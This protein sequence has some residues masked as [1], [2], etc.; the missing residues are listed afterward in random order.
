MSEG[1]VDKKEP[2]RFGPQN[3]EYVPLDAINE[4]PQVRTSY[5]SASLEELATAIIVDSHFEEDAHDVTSESFDLISPLTVGRH[6]RASAARYIADHG[7]YYKIPEEDRLQLRELVWNDDGNTIISISGHRRK[8]AIGILLERFEIETDEALVSAHVKNNIS[9]AEAQG[10]QLRENVYDRPPAQDEAR[11]IDLFYRDI[12]R[13]TGSAPSIK[14]FAAQ[15]GF[16]ETKVRDALAFASLPENVQAFTYDNLLSY[17]T[18]RRLKNLQ[19]A[20]TRLY[21]VSVAPDKIQEV[22]EHELIIFCNKLVSMELNGNT[23]QRRARMI[24]N[25]SKEIFG[26]ADYQQE[27]LFLLEPV[28]PHARRRESDVQLARLAFDVIASKLKRGA[29]SSEE[30]TQLQE[31]L[32]REQAIASSRAAVLDIFS[33]EP[34]EELKP[35][36]DDA[37]LA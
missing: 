5:N 28:E 15:V 4:L 25:K 24:E 20:Y 36:I 9:F 16:S 14:Q 6:S 11:A 8:R 10:L 17:T 37:R 23:E 31:M 18:V 13:R 19:D 32:E 33:R 1:Y 7:D 22:V 35:A 29:L 21:A 26:Q 30:I 12:Q 2:I 34:V 27:S 3:L